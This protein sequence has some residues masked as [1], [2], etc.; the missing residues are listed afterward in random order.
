M[1][2][3]ATPRK[4]DDGI[5]AVYCSIDFVRLSSA[6]CGSPVSNAPRNYPSYFFSLTFFGFGMKEFLAPLA[7]SKA[8]TANEFA[9]FVQTRTGKGHLYL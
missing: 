3:T 9:R 6:A 7:R 1:A 2:P 4:P 5:D 8:H